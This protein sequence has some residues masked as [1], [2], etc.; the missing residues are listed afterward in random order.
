MSDLKQFK[1]CAAF[2]TET[3]NIGTGDDTRAFVVCYQVND[4][5]YVSI[6]SYI[7]DVSDDVHIYRYQHEIIEFFTDLIDFGRDNQICPIVCGY[8]L[9]FDL[10]T[11]REWISSFDDVRVNAQT[12]TNVYNIDIYE[13]EE[14]IIRFWD[15]YHL[16][17]NGLAAMGETAGLAKLNG[18]W[19]YSLQRTPETHLSDDEIAYATRD[20]QVIPAYL[21]YILEANSWATEDMLGVRI[22]TKSSIV[23]QMAGKEL[24]GLKFYKRNGKIFKVGRAFELTCWQEHARDYITYAT[25]KAAFRGGL[26]F[27]ASKLA[28]VP[29]QNVISLDVTSMHHLFINGRYI[30]VHF[31]SEYSLATKQRLAE[32][33]ISIPID[34]VLR[35]YYRPFDCAFHFL[36]RFKNLRLKAGSAFEH[37]GIATLANAKFDI[38]KI[39]EFDEYSNTAG[40]EAEIDVY[41]RGFSDHC[42]GSSIFAFSKC[43]GAETCEVFVSEVELYIMSLV[44]DWDSMR[45]LSGDCTVKFAVPPDYVTLQSNIL[46]E[47][48]NAM[49][50]INKNYSE[51]SSY[52][53]DIPEIIPDAI[54]QGLKDG[55]LSNQF[56]SAYYN[57][58]VKGAFNGIYGTQAQDVMKPSF[59]WDSGDISVS[60]DRLTPDNYEERIPK[61]N[62]VLF[63]YGLRIVGG[64]RLHLVL[65]IDAIYKAFGDR[66]DI[67]GGDTDS[68]KIAL[69]DKGV[70]PESILQVLKPLHDASD[71]AI[72]F[73]MRRIRRLFPE[74]SSDLKGIGHFD[75]EPANKSSDAYDYALEAWNKCRILL[76][77][78]H[79]HIT[80]AGVAR[81]AHTVN[82]ETIA[83]MLYRQGVPFEQ[84]APLLLGYDTYIPPDISHALIKHRPY[85][86]ERFNGNVIDHLGE[87]HRVD[88]PQAV[89]LYPG[90]RFIGDMTKNANRRN[91]VYLKSLGRDID[92]GSK[93]LR[94]DSDNDKAYID[95]LF[96]G[97]IISIG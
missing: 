25:R 53:L 75:L 8:N 18:D 55:T 91:A 73:T 1:V 32:R 93:Q 95:K 20:V 90:G 23:R 45:V 3:N 52:C 96:K 63:T 57:S 62:K 64:S 46:Y 76:E 48:K 19:D 87:V 79:N 74:F 54:A 85:L 94:Y 86:G 9:M 15:T 41:R 11:L 82:I 89:A 60:D 34:D 7:P 59:V 13:H 31:T 50:T 65:A 72:A 66:V 40:L 42:F 21:R 61:R 35:Y 83:D 77:N 71:R 24:A 84:Y 10:E 58:S 28:S 38:P 97:D 68:L 80:M 22:I 4:L 39:S 30:P 12:S 47:Q 81:P 67:I 70:S 17:L 92:T 51:G 6:A 33:V 2:D 78:G 5:R 26:T 56:V 14:P 29:V 69:N 16:E 88:L 44:Y 49:K 27:T 36:I 37:W 43:M